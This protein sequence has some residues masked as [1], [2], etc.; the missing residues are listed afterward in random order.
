[1]TNFM[2]LTALCWRQS[3][4]GTIIGLALGGTMALAGPTLAIM[5]VLSVSGC[6]LF[7]ATPSHQ[8]QTVTVHVVLDACDAFY[9]GALKAAFLADD[10]HL[11]TP[12]IKADIHSVRLGVDAICPPAG[13]MPTDLT[14]AAISVIEGGAKIYADIGAKP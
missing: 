6:G 1:M 2:E 9:K 7:G 3:K 5:L 8:T 10:A 11:L 4:I 12:A 14:S 13:A